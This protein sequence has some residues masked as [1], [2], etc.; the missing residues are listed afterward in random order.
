MLGLIGALLFIVGGII[1]RS[2]AVPYS[3]EFWRIAAQPAAVIIGGLAAVSAAA[4]AFRAQRAASQT[5]LRGVRLQVAAGEKQFRQTYT[6]DVEQ[7]EADTN[8]TAVNR[9]WEKFTWIVALHQGKDMAAPGEV[10]VD[11]AVMMLESLYDDAKALGDPTLLVGIG[12]YSRLVVDA[13]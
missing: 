12:E 9:C 4:V 3:T 1:G 7:R 2:A 10:P 8:S 5:V 11:I 13:H 6:A